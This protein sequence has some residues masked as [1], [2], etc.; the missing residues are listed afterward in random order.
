MSINQRVAL[1]KKSSGDYRL[2]SIVSERFWKL[3]SG[4][5]DI[6]ERGRMIVFR[7]PRERNTVPT[8]TRKKTIYF[9]IRSDWYSIYRSWG[10]DASIY[11]KYM[12]ATSS[13]KVL[14][15]SQQHFDRFLIRPIKPYLKQNNGQRHT[16]R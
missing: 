4:D 16:E 6:Y 13:T 2:Q 1:L 8:Y 10:A 15:G 3:C 14:N 9:S 7:V 5:Y 11:Y 12:L